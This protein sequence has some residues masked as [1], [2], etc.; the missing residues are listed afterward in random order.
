[1]CLSF[2]FGIWGWSVNTSNQVFLIFYLFV[3]MVIVVSK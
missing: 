1:L 3:Y 2:G